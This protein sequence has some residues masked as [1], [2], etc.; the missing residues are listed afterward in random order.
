M[1]ASHQENEERS[2]LKRS[3]IQLK[4]HLGESKEKLV[5]VTQERDDLANELRQEREKSRLLSEER[6]KLVTESIQKSR[7]EVDLNHKTTEFVD[8]ASKNESKLIYK[9]N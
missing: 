7:L 9:K 2:E 3:W 8:L 5:Q 4:Q 6:D 1:L